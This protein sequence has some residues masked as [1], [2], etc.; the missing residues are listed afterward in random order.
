[1][2]TTIAQWDRKHWGAG[3]EQFHWWCTEAPEAFVG[4]RQVYEEM[5]PELSKMVGKKIYR[6]LQAYLDDRDRRVAERVPLPHPVLRKRS[7]AL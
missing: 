6:R 1:V 4:A 3:G 7:A 5:G 2:T